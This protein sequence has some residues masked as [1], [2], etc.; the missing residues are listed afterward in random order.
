MSLQNTV[1]L[2]CIDSSSVTF[3][4]WIDDLQTEEGGGGTKDVRIK[5]ITIM[6]GSRARL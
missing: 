3:Q 4:G 6:P 2:E 1:F 5:H